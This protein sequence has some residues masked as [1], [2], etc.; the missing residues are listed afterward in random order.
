MFDHESGFSPGLWDLWEE[1]DVQVSLAASA[2]APQ[3]P[4][5]VQETT[6]GAAG[7]VVRA[8]EGPPPGA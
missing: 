2:L 3:G 8:N 1:D 4:F 5:A 7:E 6:L